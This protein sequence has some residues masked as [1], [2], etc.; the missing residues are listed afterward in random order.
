MDNPA[1][2]HNSQKG[3]QTDHPGDQKNQDQPLPSLA[4]GDLPNSP[5][6]PAMDNFAY[7]VLESISKEHDKKC[8]VSL[9][10]IDDLFVSVYY[11]LSS[12]FVK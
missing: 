9:T 6:K 4:K 2:G 10:T 5:A 1:V 7:H 8:L 11:L 3:Y 12:Y